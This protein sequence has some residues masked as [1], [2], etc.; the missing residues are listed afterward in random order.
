MF[1]LTILSCFEFLSDWLP[2][3][4]HDICSR[5]S[6]TRRSG[7]IISS[8]IMFRLTILS[9]FEFLSVGCQGILMI[10][11]RGLPARVGQGLA[12]CSQWALS[13]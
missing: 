1:R 9:C 5:A 13:Y 7:A 12:S 10:Y 6:G 11:V 3:N 8:K 2:G 4:S